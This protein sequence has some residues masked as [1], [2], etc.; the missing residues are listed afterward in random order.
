MIT[1]ILGSFSGISCRLHLLETGMFSAELASIGMSTTAST[2]LL[3]Y[4]RVEQSV[5]V[6]LLCT[7][8]VVWHNDVIVFGEGPQE[9]IRRFPHRLDQLSCVAQIR[10]SVPVS[11][12][13]D[14]DQRSSQ[15]PTCP[16]AT[17]LRRPKLLPACYVSLDE[18]LPLP[19]A[20]SPWATF[21]SPLPSENSPVSSWKVISKT[22]DFS[23]SSA[24]II[25]NPHYK[26]LACGVLS[27][28]NLA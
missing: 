28:S 4:S 10:L 27:R 3:T 24:C 1:L 2:A 8:N 20:Q 21:S 16:A 7:Q 23:L 18:P 9:S 15:P 13:D 5:S 19:L 6:T 14:Q 25:R 17:S 26:S 11:H 12:A 22:T